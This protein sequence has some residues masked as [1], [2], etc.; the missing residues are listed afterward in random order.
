MAEN[1]FTDLLSGQPG[2]DLQ[3]RPFA[4]GAAPE[5]QAKAESQLTVAELNLVDPAQLAEMPKIAALTVGD[6]EDLAA[7]FSGEDSGNPKVKELTVDDIQDLEGIFFQF[8]VRA[9]QRAATADEAELEWSISCCSCTPCCCC[10]AADVE[11]TAAPE[12]LAA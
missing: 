10:A 1:P 7:E 9:L 12:L 8:R 6:L 2:A 3:R 4:A 11:A 5:A